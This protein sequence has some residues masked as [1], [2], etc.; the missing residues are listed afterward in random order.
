MTGVSRIASSA[1]VALATISAD[2]GWARAQAPSP[3]DLQV[4]KI[5]SEG[6]DDHV[7]PMTDGRRTLDQGVPGALVSGGDHGVEASA[8]GFMEVSRNAIVA[9]AARADVHLDLTLD[10]PSAPIEP[11]AEHRSTRTTLAWTGIIGGGALL[12]AGGVL[13]IVFESGRAALNSDRQ[14]NYG[15]AGEGATIEDP[16]D[17][18]PGESNSNTSSGCNARNVARAVFIPEI[19]A[20]SAGGILAVVG[21]ALLATDHKQE[22]SSSAAALGLTQ[23]TLL[24]QFDDRGASLRLS[25]SF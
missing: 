15:N 25:A 24:P 10:A 21:V 8:L 9:T 19:A 6:A 4:L 13:A 11:K 1:L 22:L 18:P 14:N 7:A 23:V 12:A 17:P 3:R 2:S 5:D 20:L 16:C